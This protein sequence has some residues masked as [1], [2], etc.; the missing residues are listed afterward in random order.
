L[1]PSGKALFGNAL[2]DV[3]TEAQF[4]EAGTPVRILSAS[5]DRI[6]VEANPT[7]PHTEDTESTE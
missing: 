1:R 4:I 5:G 6:V 3:V 2:A 7:I